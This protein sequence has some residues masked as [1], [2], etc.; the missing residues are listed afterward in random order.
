[1]SKNIIQ[2]YRKGARVRGR[3]R[4]EGGRRDTESAS[5]SPNAPQ[6]IKVK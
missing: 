1:M 5:V 2:G 4:R 3:R 6:E